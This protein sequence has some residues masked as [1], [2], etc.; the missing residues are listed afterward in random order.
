VSICYAMDVFSASITD[1]VK[2]ERRY[3]YY[4]RARYPSPLNSLRVFPYHKLC[5]LR[6]LRTSLKQLPSKLS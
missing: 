6:Y 2:V 3:G 5:H 1:A 4:N